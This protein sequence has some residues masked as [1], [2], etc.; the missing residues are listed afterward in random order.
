[1]TRLRAA[2]GKSLSCGA[3]VVLLMCPCAAIILG[4]TNLSE[5]GNYRGNVS[6][7]FSGRGGQ[8]TSPYYPQASAMGSS[9]GS[10]VAA[11]IGLAA[12]TLASETNGSISLPSSR[13]NVVGVKPTVGLTSRAGGTRFDFLRQNLNLKHTERFLAISA[14]T[15][16]DSIGPIC[17]SV[18]DAAILLYVIAGS[19]PLDETTIG[20]PEPVPN[21]LEA[22]NPDALK[23]AR[24]GVP[25]AFQDADSKVITQ[26]NAAL[27]VIRNLG[28]VIV[29]PAEF[30]ASQNLLEAKEMEKKVIH[31]DFKASRCLRSIIH[32][33]LTCKLD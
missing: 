31:I 7:G 3:M 9:S 12:G 1:M 18:K 20:Q 15:H 8:T 11:A 2:G 23:G 30:P 25:R 26:F 33:N 16:T 4:K 24:F 10:G 32:D 13:N 21:Y 29:D 6:A 17:R 27:E 22:L 14:S 19:D 5:W 28:G